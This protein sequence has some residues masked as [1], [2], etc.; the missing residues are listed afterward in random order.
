MTA[1]YGFQFDSG[2][3]TTTSNPSGSHVF[4]AGRL[5]EFR[6]EAERDA[7]VNEGHDRP[8]P[9]ELGAFRRRVEI[10]DGRLYAVSADGERRS[11]LIGHSV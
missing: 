5:A 9:R 11:H 3:N 6:T 1:H 8:V 10:V 4:T 2:T 7:W